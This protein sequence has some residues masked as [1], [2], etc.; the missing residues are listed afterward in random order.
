MLSKIKLKHI[1]IILLVL[2]SI[3]LLA[4]L[5]HET[6]WFDEAYSVGIASHSFKDIWVIGG[7]DVHPVLYY[8]FLH[9]IYLIA[10][11]N[12]ILFYRLFSWLCFV[13]LGI[14]GYTHIRKDFGEKKGFIFSYLVYFL[15]VVSLYTSEIRMY[16]LGMLLATIFA[17]YA[18]RIYK[19]NIT[20]S[21]YFIF[22]ITSLATAYTHYYGLMLAGIINLALF[23]YLIKNKETRKNDLKK[24]IICAVIQVLL[25]LPWLVY[26]VI[27]LATVSGGFWITLSF[28]R[29]LMELITIHFLGNFNMTFVFI[30]CVFLYIYSAYLIFK[31]GFSDA[32][33]K[34]IIFYLAVILAALII[35]IVASPILY[36]R[37]L[38][39]ITGLLIFYISDTLSNANKY[40]LITLLILIFVMSCSTMD[41]SIAESYDS[42]NNEAITYLKEN[43]NDNDIV[44]YSRISMSALTERMREK[45]INAYYVSTEYWTFEAYKAFDPYMHI[46]EDLSVLD[47]YHGNIWVLEENSSDLK[48][49]IKEQYKVVD[50]NTSNFYQPYKDIS[51][52]VHKLVK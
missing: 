50:E 36:F 17:F 51:F 12:S 32:S 14:F 5:F 20:K 41:S 21:T 19:N 6:L 30:G 9:L 13:L 3:F 4:P 29:T 1:H 23:I 52:T 10:G 2:G 46:V 33:K 27:Q 7:H 16:S 26:F 43:I 44:I 38:L 24:F 48:N 31:N 40:V 28:P 35:S 22:M 34:A 37:Y 11:N 15:P 18:Y 45:N 8:F 39:I 25:Y 49:R 47:D 42:K